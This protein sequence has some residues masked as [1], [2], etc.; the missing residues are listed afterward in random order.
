MSIQLRFFRR[1]G[2]EP[3]CVGPVIICDACGELIDDG[4]GRYLFRPPPHEFDEDLQPFFAHRGVCHHRLEKTLG[5]RLVPWVPLEEFF[6]YLQHNT[7]SCV[8][9]RMSNEGGT[10]MKVEAT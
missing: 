4:S 1:C 8:R 6:K 5:D 2:N 10:T 7:S 3:E 9:E